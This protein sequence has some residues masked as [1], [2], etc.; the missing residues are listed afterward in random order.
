[1][2]ST[3]FVTT[4]LAFLILLIACSGHDSD[5]IPF[6]LRG[7][8]VWVYDNATD[9]EFYGGRVEANYF[10]KDSGLRKAGSRAYSTARQYNIADWSYV[11]CTVTP[12]SDCATK[13]R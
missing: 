11:C 6:A 9:K 10:S 2:K 13:V 7:F 1:M 8:D 5:F 12:W 3:F 4:I